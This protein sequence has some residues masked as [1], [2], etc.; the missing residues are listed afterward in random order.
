MVFSWTYAAVMCTGQLR[1]PLEV[2]EDG[3]PRRKR[4]GVRVL[5]V[6]VAPGFSIRSVPAML[7]ASAIAPSA[8]A[9][10]QACRIAVQATSRP[11]SRVCCLCVRPSCTSCSDRACWLQSRL[12]EVSNISCPGV[13]HVLHVSQAEPQQ[14]LAER[15]SEQQQC[16]G[17]CASRS[18][19]CWQ[20]SSHL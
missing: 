1:A 5:E 7:R 10:A 19:Q 15:S 3:V 2:G 13:E 12:H 14:E 16:D 18:G 4:D 20:H 11:V 17:R 8:A 6:P 9:P